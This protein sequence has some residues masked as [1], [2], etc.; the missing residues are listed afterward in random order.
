VRRPLL[1]LAAAA[2]LAGPALDA[3]ASAMPPPTHVI[4]L[5][6]AALPAATLA[7]FERLV[8]G[9]EADRYLDRNPATIPTAPLA[10]CARLAAAQ[11]E[12]CVRRTLSRPHGGPIQHVAVILEAAPGGRVRMTCIGP[13]K[14][15][16]HVRAQT[17]VLI[18]L[19]KGV[20]PDRAVN[21]LVRRDAAGCI[22]AAVE[23]TYGP[24]P[25]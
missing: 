13:G 15:M 8:D 20:S 12:P 16:R 5:R 10:G 3:S 14:A 17:R 18:D 25:T 22:I 4:V 23:E 19:H 24:A 11:R 21:R 7:R 6:P 2:A 1:A 9:L